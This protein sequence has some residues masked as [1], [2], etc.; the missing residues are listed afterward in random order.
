[1][2][3][4]LGDLTIGTGPHFRGNCVKSESGAWRHVIESAEV[5]PDRLKRT[6]EN[7]FPAETAS[8]RQNPADMTQPLDFEETRFIASD[9][10][11][12]DC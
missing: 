11:V 6:A 3:S 2:E 7:A 10:G 8:R 12:L 9:Y 5:W 1:M 4:P